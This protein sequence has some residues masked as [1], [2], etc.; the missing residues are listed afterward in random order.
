MNHCDSVIPIVLIFIFKWVVNFH[1]EIYINIKLKKHK[2]N[3]YSAKK[4]DI[5]WYQDWTRRYSVVSRLN[6]LCRDMFVIWSNGVDPWFLMWSFALLSTKK[7]VLCHN[8]NKTHHIMR[9]KKK[10]T[11]YVDRI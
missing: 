1:I 9:D 6:I 11:K 2:N 3:S 7:V 8:F 5:V 4:E 10:T